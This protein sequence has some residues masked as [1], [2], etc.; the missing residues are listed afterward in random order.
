MG[1]RGPAPRPAIDR[2]AEK[3]AWTD[4]GCLE[5]IGATTKNGYGI[6]FVGQAIRRGN[7]MVLAH[8]WSYEYQ[9]G[10]IPAGMQVDH[11]CRNRACVLPL[12]HEIVTSR[13]N[14]LRGVS[15]AA[16]AAKRTH[17]PQGHPFSGDNLYIYPT[18]GARECRT[19]RRENKRTRQARRAS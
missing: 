19:C 13:E 8:R 18:T 2:F 11:L 5:W 12:H 4:S 7:G 15:P 3:V 16:V 1:L 17:C 10:P 9:V 6:F 14:T